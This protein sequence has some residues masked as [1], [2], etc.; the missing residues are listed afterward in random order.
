[1]Q[2]ERS[3]PHV[4]RGGGCIPSLAARRPS[5][6]VTLARVQRQSGLSVAHCEGVLSPRGLP[7]WRWSKNRGGGGGVGMSIGGTE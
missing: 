5:V 1:M 7:G 4:E 3:I 2:S 6:P